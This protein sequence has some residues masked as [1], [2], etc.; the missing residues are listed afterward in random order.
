MS[1]SIEPIAREYVYRRFKLASTA[2]K[3]KIINDWVNKIEDSQALVK[4]FKER[5][6]DPNGKKILDAGSGPGGVSIAFAMAGAEVSGVD[7]EKELFEISEKHAEGHGVKLHFFLYDGN[8][9]PFRDDTFDYAISVSVLEH[10]TD[11][12]LYLSEILRVIK[13]S[14]KCYLAFPNKLWPKET[15]TGIWGLTYL[16]GFLRPTV[17]SILKRNPLGE[18]NLHFYTYWNLLGM[19][20][21]M[22]ARGFKWRIVPEEGQAQKGVK[23]IIKTILGTFGISYKTFLSHILV[24]LEK[25]NL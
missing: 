12:V 19:L 3:E 7:V 25:T 2:E 13:P 11:P 5:V 14:G 1:F 20:K 10:T 18:N 15:H 24:I 16:P 22:K 4:D 17:I 9:L 8:K 6:G 21:R 23:K